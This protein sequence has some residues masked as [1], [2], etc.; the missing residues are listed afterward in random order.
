VFLGRACFDEREQ[1]AIGR[2]DD[3]MVATRWR[4]FGIAEKS[5]APECQRKEQHSGNGRDPE[6]ARI[7]RNENCDEWNAFAVNRESQ[8]RYLAPR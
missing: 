6:Q 2:T 5:D 4:A 3:K 8:K 7:Q 1:N